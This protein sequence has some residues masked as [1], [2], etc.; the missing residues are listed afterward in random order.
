MLFLYVKTYVEV[1]AE[2]SVLRC[3]LIVRS[4]KRIRYTEK[5]SYTSPFSERRFN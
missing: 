1:L 5:P 4:Q 3:S 2:T